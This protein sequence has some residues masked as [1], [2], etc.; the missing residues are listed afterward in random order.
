MNLRRLFWPALTVL[1]VLGGAGIVFAVQNWEPDRDDGVPTT[2]VTRGDLK[3]DVYANGEL[4]AGRS[5]SL[6]APPITGG[7]LRIVQVASTGTAVK[8][9][10]VVIEFDPAEQQY[11]LEQSRSELNEAEQEIVK[12]KADAAVQAAVEQ[13]TLLT[14][15][16]DVRRAE[17]DVSAGELISA[18]EAKK[19]ALNLEEAKRRIAQLEE[20]VKSRTVTS[21]AGLAALQEKRNKAQIAMDRAKATIDTLVMRSPMDGL[22]ALRTNPDAS[23]G[24]G[25]PGMVLPEYRV[26]DTIGP[27]RA[28]ADVLEAGQMQIRARVN[29]NDRANLAVGQSA[30]IRVEAA[31]GRFFAGRIVSLGALASRGNWWESNQAGRQFDA[32]FQITDRDVRLRPGGSVRIVVAG[33]AVENTLQIPRQAVFAREGKTVVYVRDRDRFAPREV[34]VSH[35]SENRVAVEGIDEGV[36]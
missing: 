4:R 27:G 11:A 2:R 19:R 3:L 20:D 13:V 28:L 16:F 14:A 6:I 24:F 8:A 22:V 15:R 7:S 35:R 33:Q 17:L 23:G 36:E 32:F 12:M 31:P 1:V 26:G 10:E 34:K 5:L 18:V 30:A 29:E 25:F 9:G 21:A